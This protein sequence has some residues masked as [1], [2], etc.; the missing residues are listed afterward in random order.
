MR[1]IAVTAGG[2]LALLASGCE[3]TQS[4][5][6]RLGHEGA[7]L[8]ADTRTADLG[9]VNHDVRIARTAILQGSGRT[10]AA[11]QLTST[12]AQPQ[13]D[14]PVL[15][16][17]RGAKGVSVYRNDVQGN[18][19]S[20]H[21]LPLLRGR[22]RAW[23]VDDQVLASG[24]PKSVQVRVGKPRTDKPATG[25]AGASNSFTSTPPASKP[26]G[27]KSAVSKTLAAGTASNPTASKSHAASVSA[28]DVQLRSLRLGSDIAGPYLTG[29]VVNRSGIAQRNMPIYA[30][31]LRG[32][33]V[34][35]AG[36]A[37]VPSL[38]AGAGAS[39]GAS[40]RTSTG[41]RTSTRTSTRTRTGTSTGASTGTRTSTNT[42]AGAGAGKPTVF[43]IYFV[44]NP[45]GAR[46]ELTT[47]PTIKS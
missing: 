38:P 35:A 18:Q 1:A 32:K 36:R 47:A 2:A 11:V 40:T 25:A 27:R 9:G 15:I 5:S 20:L 17:V 34:T 3:R 39:T 10:A 28:G 46:I 44:G 41:T 12:V 42:G 4:E 33:R 24:A 43:R 37:L 29:V 14:I 8:I 13:V 21:E 6:A 31:A 30:V 19:T 22:R 23:W 45:S 16:D 7:G 26:A